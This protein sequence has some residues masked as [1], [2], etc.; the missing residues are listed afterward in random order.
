MGKRLLSIVILLALAL[1]PGSSDLSGTNAKI[2]T[3]FP[4]SDA[5]IWTQFPPANPTQGLPPSRNVGNAAPLPGNSNQQNLDATAWTPSD[6]QEAGSL[7]AIAALTPNDIWA[8]GQTRDELAK[9]LV[10]HWDGETWST[11][12][13]FNAAPSPSDPAYS[14]PPR[15]LPQ[16]GGTRLYDVAVL[17]ANNVWVVGVYHVWVDV[18]TGSGMCC[19]M[20]QPLIAHWNGKSWK[21]MRDFNIAKG[22][23]QEARH[24]TEA[25]FASR[26]SVSLNAIAAIAPDDIW[27][28]GYRR[29]G[30]ALALHWDGRAWTNVPAPG[31]KLTSISALSSDNIW[32]AG[33]DRVIH[34]DGKAWREA[35]TGPDSEFHSI[36]ALPTG[37]V[38][39]VGD[40]Y[41][42]GGSG[43]LS[44]AY[45]VHWDGK[46]WTYSSLFSS[47]SLGWISA[48]TSVRS[49]TDARV[50]TFSSVLA[51]APDDV[52]I[53]GGQDGAPLLM[54][55][56]G[57]YWHVNACPA[58][59]VGS[60][61]GPLVDL[62]AFSDG[63][64]WAAGGSRDRF[65]TASEDRGF[66][67]I[68][69][70]GP[71]PPGEPSPPPPGA[72]AHVRRSTL[73][74]PAPVIPTRPP[75]PIP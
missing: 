34:W 74:P 55:W 70:S 52:W 57:E 44:S 21:I 40:R 14:R 58:R 38:W 12:A 48:D 16:Q 19:W 13:T 75:T 43:D 64:V 11:V 18:P 53:A 67:L 22:E 54:H 41:I 28:V 29:G 45:V 73:I 72:P 65:W 37:E 39:A 35:Y 68:P 33:G 5:K 4:P 10:V 66:V 36:T 6:T 23:K 46:D 1:V 50:H 3:Q 27:A 63:V 24:I 32:A 62:V 69:G 20:P 59:G 9:A 25:L 61:L 2:W 49:P 56:D 17:S 26:G 51:L 31:S 47:H 42:I 7:S 71:C 8:V 30:G 60:A 15:G